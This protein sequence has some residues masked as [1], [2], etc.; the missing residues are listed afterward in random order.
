[1]AWKETSVAL[2]VVCLGVFIPLEARSESQRTLLAQAA[3]LQPIEAGTPLG[4]QAQ[5]L[6]LPQPGPNYQGA[7]QVLEESGQVAQ[8]EAAVSLIRQTQDSGLLNDD[9]VGSPVYFNWADGQ[10]MGVPV[11]DAIGTWGDG[12]YPYTAD[13]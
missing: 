1:M 3:D 6:P 7:D 9:Y 11:D 8:Q 4:G 13:F 10:Q 5:P 2:G 12:Y